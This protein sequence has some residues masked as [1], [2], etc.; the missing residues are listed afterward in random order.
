MST[1]EEL[2]AKF[3][4][5]LEDFEDAMVAAALVRYWDVCMESDPTDD[6]FNAI[7]RVLQEYMAPSAYVA[8]LRSREPY[9]KQ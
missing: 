4:D 9:P 2:V 1:K 5:I 7:D 3:R 8:W 6:I